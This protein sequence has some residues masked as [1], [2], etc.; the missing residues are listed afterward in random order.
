MI[1]YTPPMKDR[2]QS[3]VSRVGLAGPAGIPG[4]FCDGSMCSVLY[5][6]DQHINFFVKLEKYLFP[7]AVSQEI[8]V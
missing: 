6:R 4:V 7:L 3:T 8:P 1:P 2:I 5:L